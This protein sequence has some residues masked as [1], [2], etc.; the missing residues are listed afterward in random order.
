MYQWICFY[1]QVGRAPGT[2]RPPRGVS[3]LLEDED[4]ENH[5]NHNSLHY[6]HARQCCYT[7]LRLGWTN[8]LSS[9]SGSVKP[10][11]KPPSNHKKHKYQKTHRHALYNNKIPGGQE[12]KRNPVKR[13]RRLINREIEKVWNNNTSTKKYIGTLRIRTKFLEPKKWKGILSKGFVALA[14]KCR[15]NTWNTCKCLGD[16]FLTH[17][18][19]MNEIRL[20]SKRVRLWFSNA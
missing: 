7:S 10:E 8:R 19:E 3:E 18:V 4:D 2:T 12:V 14:S 1:R 9:Y 11:N 20:A 15:N 13:Y 16:M 5:K 6:F 17:F